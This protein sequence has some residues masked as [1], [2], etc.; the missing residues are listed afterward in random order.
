MHGGDPMALFNDIITSQ[1]FQ[2]GLNTAIVSLVLAAAG[3]LVAVKT[4]G[5][6]LMHA[7]RQRVLIREKDREIAELRR[8]L[9]TVRW[10]QRPM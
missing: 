6:A 7:E 1:V 9:A 4:V 3:A 10:R 8:E 2:I 5:Q